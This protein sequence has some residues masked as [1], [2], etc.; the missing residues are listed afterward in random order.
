MTTKQPVWYNEY[1]E[2]VRDNQETVSAKTQAQI[3]LLLASEADELEQFEQELRMAEMEATHEPY[4]YS[5][6]IPSSKERL[7]FIGPKC[8][9]KDDVIANFDP[10]IISWVGERIGITA[11]DGVKQALADGHFVINVAG[12]INNEAQAKITIEA[13][14]GRV[15]HDLTAVADTMETV[16]NTTNQK[17][18]VHCAMGMERSVLAVVWFMATKWRMQLHQA[19]KH[20]QT[21]R[22]IALNR[23]DWIAM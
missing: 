4:R 2:G 10:S 3:D 7:N 11:E 21:K 13:G 1:K 18:V 12:E 9:I 22:P 20:I 16:F 15:I 19:L 5:K 8:G 6:H 17:I 14:N 23:L